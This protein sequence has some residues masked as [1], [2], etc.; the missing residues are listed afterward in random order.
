[1]GYECE[2][3]KIGGVKFSGFLPI[4]GR[5]LHGVCEISAANFRWSS[6]HL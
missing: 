6:G 2:I 3:S 4:S 5:F 1:M